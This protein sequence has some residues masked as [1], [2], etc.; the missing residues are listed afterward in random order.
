MSLFSV[1]N[2]YLSKVPKGKNP[3]TAV[4]MLVFG[5]PAKE[6]QTV[7]KEYDKRAKREP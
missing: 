7:Q 1:G 3:I 5:T 4:A 2:V 6:G